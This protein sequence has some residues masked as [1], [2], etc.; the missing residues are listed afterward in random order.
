MLHFHWFQSAHSEQLCIRIHIAQVVMAGKE[1]SVGLMNSMTSNNEEETPIHGQSV[2]SI[3]RSTVAHVE[4]PVGDV[5]KHDNPVN[6]DI[7]INCKP[8]LLVDIFS[9]SNLTMASAYGDVRMPGKLYS[10]KMNLT[11]FV[12]TQLVNEWKISTKWIA[13][14]K[15]LDLKSKI[16]KKEVLEKVKAEVE[17]RSAYEITEC[18]FSLT[19]TFVREM[20]KDYDG[21]KKVEKDLLL[22]EDSRFLHLLVDDKTF[23]K[24][25]TPDL[26]YYLRDCCLYDDVVRFIVKF[27]MGK[28][29]KN[30]LKEN[31]NH[32]RLHGNRKFCEIILFISQFFG[33]AELVMKD[34]Q[35]KELWNAL[36]FLNDFVMALLDQCRIAHQKFLDNP[37]KRIVGRNKRDDEE[38]DGMND[39]ASSLESYSIVEERS[40]SKRDKK[41]KGSAGLPGSIPKKLQTKKQVEVIK[42]KD[43][44]GS[45]A[46]VVS[47]KD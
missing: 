21:K 3:N 2:M 30:S 18:A 26:L 7:M 20:F 37:P 13:W 42:E 39:V 40:V 44:T 5:A 45:L 38:S 25:T 34:S 8:V 28:F 11:E 47:V 19:F 32:R 6:L 12:E 46:L 15:A 10:S 9:G 24:T 1:A 27:Y 14:V 17:A 4:N 22:D 29:D 36:S 33:R 16:K 31:C 23:S 35:V 43:S 41:R